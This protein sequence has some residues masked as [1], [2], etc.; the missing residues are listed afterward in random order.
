MPRRS[1]F[2]IVLSD[3]EQKALEAMARHYTS[4]YRD[5]IRAKII[6]FAARGL[7]NDHIAARLDTPRQIVSKWLQRF[8]QLRLHGLE[9]QPRRGRPPPLSPQLSGLTQLPH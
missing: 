6:L 7:R 3:E 1:P 5:V 2:P 8:F 9:Q 4:P